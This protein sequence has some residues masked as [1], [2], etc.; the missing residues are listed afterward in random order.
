MY[1]HSAANNSDGF[2][3]LYRILEI[4]HPRLRIS[5][6]GI[7][8][9]IEAPYSD[10]EDDSIYTFITRY[11]N[12]LIHEQLSPENRAY[13]KQEQTMFVLNALT[14]DKR[15]KEGLAY[16]EGTIQAYQR[17]S[18]VSS[19]T[20]FPIDLEIDEVAVTIDERS[21]NYVV[22][23]K[24]TTARVIN[25]YAMSHIRMLEATDHASI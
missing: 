19:L 21:D 4:I 16:V 3:L 13:N 22:G 5:K 7:H 1:I 12:Y 6:G 23:D 14:F 15:F 24:L 18:S 2:K 20:P 11:K 25:P 17:D 8:K 9:T 10:V